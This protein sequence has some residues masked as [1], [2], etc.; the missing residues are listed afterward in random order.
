MTHEEF[1]ALPAINE[2]LIRQYFDRGEIDNLI[3]VMDFLFRQKS[4]AEMLAR[5]YLA[6]N[7]VL[8]QRLEVLRAGASEPSLPAPRQRTST[9]AAP[10]RQPAT[11][12]QPS[13]AAAAKTP[14]LSLALDL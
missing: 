11:P 6:Q 1:L 4:R 2:T 10:T 7:E 12:K 8:R 3:R 9:T 13:A 14:D 5:A